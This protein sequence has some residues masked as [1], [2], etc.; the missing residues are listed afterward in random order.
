MFSIH[1]KRGRA[2]QGG[3]AAFLTFSSLHVRFEPPGAAQAAPRLA[4]ANAPPYTHLRR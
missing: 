4:R 2:P 1:L 3:L